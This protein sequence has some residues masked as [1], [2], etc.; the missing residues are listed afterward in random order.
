M[1]L[2]HV[3]W[4]G[5]LMAASS[6]SLLLLQ[7]HKKPAR[8]APRANSIPTNPDLFFFVSDD[9]WVAEILN[10][11]TLALYRPHTDTPQTSATLEE[12]EQ[13]LATV[14]RTHKILRP[15]TQ[16]HILMLNNCRDLLQAYNAGE[17][18]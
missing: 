1:A 13:E 11:H 5:V 17:L 2:P 16:Q 9:Q 14:A 18:P 3:L 15:E 6:A 8:Q 7:G 12:I 10:E 4:L